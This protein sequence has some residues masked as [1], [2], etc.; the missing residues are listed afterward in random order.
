MDMTRIRDRMVEHHVTRRGIRDPGVTEAM[1]TVPREKFVPPGSEEFA[2]ED[3]P[4]SIGEGQTISQPF[5]VALMLEKANLDAGDTVLEVGTGSGYASALLS[6]ITRHVYSIE[7][8]ERLALQA[9]ER[10]EKLEYRN[11]DVRVGDGSKGWAEAAP[12]DAIIV[13]AS[14]PE[15]PTAL[16]EQLGLGGRL[17]IP[18][19]RC[20][21]QRLKRVTRTG[22]ATFEEEDLGGVLFV[23]LIGEDAWTATHPMYTATAPSLPGTLASEPS[24]PQ[25][26]QGGGMGKIHPLPALPEG[27]VDYTDFQQTFWAVQRISW[28]VFTLLLLTCLLGLLGRGGPF[29][30]QTLLLADG[31]VDFPVI[32]RWNAPED[33]TVNFTPS[34]ED[35]VFTIDAA[36]LQTFSVQGIDPPQ[37]ATFVRAGRIGYVFPADPA[38]LTQIVFRLQTQLPGPRRATIGMGGETRSQSTFIFP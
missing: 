11:I 26:A 1:R 10:F 2:Y 18:V 38:G 29:S 34:S 24:S 8:H 30:R 7:R 13:S 23:P 31:S 33:M 36:F 16:K 20:D 21:A 14:A 35:R 5:I 37:K 17:I 25:D 9:K 32:S 12:F 22:D 19:G 4:L 3:A 27:V 6:R 28:I 15:V